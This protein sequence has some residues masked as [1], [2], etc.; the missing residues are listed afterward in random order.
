MSGRVQGLDMVGILE[1]TLVHHPLVGGNGL[2][3][4]DRARTMNAEKESWVGHAVLKREGYHTLLGVQGNEILS[5]VH[6]GDLEI[7][8]TLDVAA[9]I[10][11][12]PADYCGHRS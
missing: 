9:A 5:A 4:D 11:P 1:W 10:C 6:A 8:A 7:W 2:I 12:A 3:G